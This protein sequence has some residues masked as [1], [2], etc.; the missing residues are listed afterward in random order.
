[1]KSSDDVIRSN[2][3]NLTDRQVLI[4]VK[5]IKSSQTL[6]FVRKRS[7]WY[8]N[9]CKKENINTLFFLSS[10]HLFFHSC[11]S[12]HTQT[13]FVIVISCRLGGIIIIKKTC[14]NSHP[15]IK[16]NRECLMWDNIDFEKKRNK[17]KRNSTYVCDAP[18]R[19]GS[20]HTAAT[21]QCFSSACLIVLCVCF[22]RL[23]L[24][25]HAFRERFFSLFMTDY[26]HTH[27]FRFDALF[28]VVTTYYS[29]FFCLPK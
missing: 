19:S 11:P 14:W 9:N 21:S 12:S 7:N 28:V 2:H 13:L 18:R 1:M 4:Q 29:L 15:S 8:N 17:K 3:I 27:T 24:C 23:L 20:K 5:L 25:V 22:F 16:H 10:C 26:R 6:S